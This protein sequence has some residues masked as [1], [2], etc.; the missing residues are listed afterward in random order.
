M[1]NGETSCSITPV[2]ANGVGYCKFYNGMLVLI[3][4]LK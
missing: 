2:F 3:A 1:K 4:L